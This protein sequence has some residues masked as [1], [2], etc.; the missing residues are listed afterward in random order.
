MLVQV[1][2]DVNINLIE[3]Y[4]VG[5]V[6]MSDIIMANSVG[7]KGILVRT[8]V[9]EGSLADFRH[10]WIDAEPDYVADNVL[11]AVKWIIEREISELCEGVSE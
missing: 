2:K 3:S 5:D 1:K 11:E 10:T 4:V 7:A 8:G 9:G 6:G